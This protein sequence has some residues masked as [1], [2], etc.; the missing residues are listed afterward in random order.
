[1]P[2][3][4]R[5]SGLATSYRMDDRLITEFPAE[6]D[7]LEQAEPVYEELPGW[8]EDITS[9]RDLSE[10][11]DT[12]RKYLDRIQEIADVPIGLVSVGQGREQTIVPKS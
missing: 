11:P 7:V 1:M 5:P 8:Q 4:S 2:T 9:A 10:L 12:A 3:R 6:V